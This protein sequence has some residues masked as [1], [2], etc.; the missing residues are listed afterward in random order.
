MYSGMPHVY[1]SVPTAPQ[2][3]D[4]SWP[5]DS[6]GASHQA[7]PAAWTLWLLGVT[8]EAVP[9]VAAAVPPSPP[10]PSLSPPPPPPSLSPPLPSPPPASKVE[11]NS[12]VFAAVVAACGGA[13]LLL[14]VLVIIVFLSKRGS[15]THAVP[16]SQPGVEMAMQGASQIDQVIPGRV[17]QGGPVPGSSA[18]HTLA[19]EM[20]RKAA[21]TACRHPV[22]RLAHKRTS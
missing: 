15:S 2:D 9:T 16:T 17:V 22:A 6:I 13:A 20:E 4:A 12:A 7:T 1:P 11:E 18:P 21:R 8:V 3:V 14:A 10:P 19:T 5:Q